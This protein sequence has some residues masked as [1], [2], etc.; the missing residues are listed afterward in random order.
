MPACAMYR[1]PG[2]SGTP[3]HPI[4]EWGRQRFGGADVSADQ[5]RADLENSLTQVKLDPAENVAL[6]AP[7]LD[8]P[9]PE[10]HAPTSTPEELRRRQLAALTACASALRGSDQRT[11]CSFQSMTPSLYRHQF[12]LEISQSDVVL[13]FACLAV[14]FFA[15][16]FLPGGPRI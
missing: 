1:T 4:T 11:K 7:L 15:A 8:I 13:M 2:S 5:R 16:A 10:G 9:V 3:W 14:P 6:L 12:G